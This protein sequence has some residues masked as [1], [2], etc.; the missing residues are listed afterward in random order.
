MGRAAAHDRRDPRLA[1]SGDGADDS[2]LRAFRRAAARPT[3]ALGDGAVRARRARRL[4]VRAGVRRR[5]GPA[6][7]AAQGGGAAR[8]RRGASRQPPLRVR[9]RGGDRRS[10]DRRLDRR[11]TSE[12][13]MRRSSS[14][15]A[16]SSAT[17]PAS[18]SRCAV[19]ATST[20][21][22][23]PATRDLHSGMYGGASLNAMHA[24]MQALSAVLPR[25]G[26]LPE[27]LRAGI[28]P[29][30]RGRARRRGRRCRPGPTRSPPPARGRPML[31]QPTSSISAPGPSP[32]S[33]C[34]AS[35]AAR[36]ILQK[37][38]IPVEAEANVSIRLVGDQDPAVIAPALRSAA[39][40]GGSGRRRRRAHDAV[41]GAAGPDR[42][43][44]PPPCSS[45][46]TRS[47]RCSA[48]GRCSFAREVR[49]RSS[50]HS[51]PAGSRPS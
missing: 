10:R 33:T 27:P 22:C 47:R 18:T 32:P 14:T 5:Q 36:P 30:T 31:P 19:S 4:A 45:G 28:V 8:G 23:A 26:R 40:R 3:R 1:R 48:C 37:T 16:W 15:A 50:P 41:L 25:D 20:S 24:L 34:T 35:R 44:M 7:H 43:P 21:R 12:A 6:L 2:L 17:C 29:P 9:R 49:S 13:R 42:R 39:P 46:S 11:R 38:V 51:P